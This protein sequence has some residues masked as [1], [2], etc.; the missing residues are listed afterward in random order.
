MIKILLPNYLN[1][2]TLSR[3]FQSNVT[4]IFGSLFLY[5]FNM[6][7]LLYLYSISAFP[8]PIWLVLQ[9]HDIICK[10]NHLQFLCF[11]ITLYF[12]DEITIIMLKKKNDKTLPCLILFSVSTH[13]LFFCILTQYLHFWYMFFILSPIPS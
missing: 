11:Y 1:L 4:F 10:F 6:L 2:S 13:Q 9:C 8:I 7:L 12:C 3:S 5:T